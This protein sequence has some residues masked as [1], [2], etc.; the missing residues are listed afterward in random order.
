M[1]AFLLYHGGELH[2]QTENKNGMAEGGKKQTFFLEPV[3]QTHLKTLKGNDWKNSVSNDSSEIMMISI[4]LRA[5][6]PGC[7]LPAGLATGKVPQGQRQCHQE[8]R[9]PRAQW[10]KERPPKVGQLTRS[11]HWDLRQLTS[12]C[13]QQSKE[14]LTQKGNLGSAL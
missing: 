9:G 3:S 6:E 8:L 4:Q 12:A 14:S 1:H 5:A 7:V 2:L 10:L 11:V 13:D